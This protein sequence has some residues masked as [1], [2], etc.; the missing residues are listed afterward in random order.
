MALNFGTTNKGFRE[1]E[2]RFFTGE[3]KNAAIVTIAEGKATTVA[4]EFSS[5][6]LSVERDNYGSQVSYSLGNFSGASR[7][8][9]VQI[10]NETTGEIL[11]TITRDLNGS[12]SSATRFYSL[13]VI[14]PADIVSITFAGDGCGTANGATVHGYYRA[15]LKSIFK[16]EDE[17]D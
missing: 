4:I 16:D 14:R 9:I 2:R 5:K 11:S 7:E 15:E 17:S 10:K 12:F 3:K 8:I 13:E 1:F 6:V